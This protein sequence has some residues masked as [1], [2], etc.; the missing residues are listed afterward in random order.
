[1]EPI[2]QMG[3]ERRFKGDEVTPGWS[4]TAPSCITPSRVLS[5]KLL[6]F[7]MSGGMRPWDRMEGVMLGRIKWQGLVG[8]A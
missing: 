4:R 2:L 6:V 1:M 5:R 8:E 7:G 3:D